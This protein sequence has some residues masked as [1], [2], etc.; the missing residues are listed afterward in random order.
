MFFIKQI[1]SQNEIRYQKVSPA[2]INS[3]RCRII[4]LNRLSMTIKLP[5]NAFYNL[6]YNRR[7][8]DFIM[9]NS[10]YESDD[11]DSISHSSQDERSY[12]SL[13]I[14]LVPKQ[15]K[16]T[17]INS[18]SSSTSCRRK[19]R[20]R[21]RSISDTESSIDYASTKSSDTESLASTVILSDIENN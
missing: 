9:L 14:Y 7:T 20:K 5:N 4:Q 11:E 21:S 16:T 19:S 6:K 2:T 18:S 10:L 12:P 8:D 15:A 3:L 1:S 17:S 13:Y